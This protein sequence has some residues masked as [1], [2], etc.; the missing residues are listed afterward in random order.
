MSGSTGVVRILPVYHQPISRDA[1]KQLFEAEPGFTVVATAGSAGETVRAVREHAP[2]V[3]LLD[4]TL[5]NGT[6]FEV[7]TA[8]EGAASATYAV[9]VADDVER[10]ELVEAFRL[11]VR[12]LVGRDL[13]TTL[14]FEC[15]R[16]VASGEYWLGN[17][18]LSDLIGELRH[19][20]DVASR[21]PIDRL[22]QREAGIIAAVLEGWSNGAIAVQLGITE[23]TV[24]N[25]LSH[26]YDKVGVSSRL[27]LAVFAIHHKL[28]GR[29]RFV[30]S[31]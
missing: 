29:L 16:C 11:G 1:L 30:P 20:R 5:P 28:T 15:V 19:S 6:V 25:H 27:E 12:G 13:P 24:K 4:S 10:Q 21:A 8:L 18:R 2:D 14:L 9:L 26:I 23:Q 7:L 3:M 17:D 31:R 22:T